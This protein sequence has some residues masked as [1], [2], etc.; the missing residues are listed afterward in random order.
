MEKEQDRQNGI[1]QGDLI[2][3][4]QFGSSGISIY[5]IIIGN[6]L[7]LLCNIF[8][9]ISAF[10]STRK[11]IMFM[12]CL[13]CTCG[14]LSSVVLRGY[15]GALTQAVNLVRNF[16][17][18]KGKMTNAVKVVTIAAIIILGLWANNL[19]AIGLLPILAS[20]EY[21]LFI[22]FTDDVN[23]IR[24][25]IILNNILWIG[26]ELA[27]MNYASIVMETGI[28][29]S[30]I[31]SIVKD[32]ISNRKNGIGGEVRTEDSENETDNSGVNRRCQHT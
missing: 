2:H 18:Y 12:Q 8:C 11:K 31:V 3:M 9:A 20:V 16:I 4:Q 26:Y 27:I 28:I 5:E 17:V 24:L 22:M 13:D 7:G 30:S 21:T 6:I 19:G 15:T 14:A 23:K 25:A 1:G 10:G 32:K 29:I